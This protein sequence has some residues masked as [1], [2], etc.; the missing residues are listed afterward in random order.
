MRKKLLA[1]LTMIVLT[2]LLAGSVYSAPPEGKDKKQETP[3]QLPLDANQISGAGFGNYFYL[4]EFDGQTYVES[5]KSGKSYYKAAWI[6]DCD[7]D[8]TEEIVALAYEKRKGVFG[9]FLQVFENGSTGEPDWESQA[10]DGYG[11]TNVVMVADAD[12]DEEG[13]LE[14]IVGLRTRAEVWKYGANGYSRIWQGPLEEPNLMH[15][16]VGDADSDGDNDIVAG[17]YAG[18]GSFVA[19]LYKSPGVWYRGVSEAHGVHS[20]VH[21]VRI[22]DV[23]GDGYNEVIG[24]TDNR[25]VVW[26]HAGS[27]FRIDFRSEQMNG[28]TAG[29]DAYDFDNDG[30]AEIVV[31][32]SNGN[33]SEVHAF[34]FVGGE[35]GYDDF[36]SERT[37]RFLDTVRIGDADNDGEQEF[38]LGT[39]GFIVYEYSP[40]DGFFEDY[41][42]LF[43]DR[44]LFIEFAWLSIQ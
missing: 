8:Q 22:H 2:A 18:D 7:N 5:W 1:I 35:T 11:Y 34:R 31:A 28:G 21:E 27:S 33:D 39:E 13:D 44:N 29:V 17:T 42:K 6:G 12:N 23:D 14:I 30:V 36:W 38:V 32:V 43:E 24:G 41:R 40:S 20:R 16:D 19:Y 37:E 15:I 10:L 26:E 3:L 9:V 25:L 4:F